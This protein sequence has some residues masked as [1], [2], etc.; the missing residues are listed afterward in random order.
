[1][2]IFSVAIRK[3]IKDQLRY[4]ITYI[5]FALIYQAADVVDDK[6]DVLGAVVVY[7]DGEA[8]VS[9]GDGADV[10]DDGLAGIFRQ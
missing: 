8:A 10:N 5:R 1:M 7:A 4:I 3:H 9:A 2:H 6:I